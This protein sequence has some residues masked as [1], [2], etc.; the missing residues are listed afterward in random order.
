MAAQLPPALLARLFQLSSLF[1]PERT[2]GQLIAPFILLVPMRLRK[3]SRIWEDDAMRTQEGFSLIELLIVVAIILVLAAIA[4]PNYIRARIVANE[5]AAVNALRSITSA[6]IIYKITYSDAG[7]SPTIDKL[8]PSASPSS[9][10]A[11]LIQSELSD[12]PNQKSGYT[13]SLVGTFDTFE[14]NA[15]PVEPGVSGV[16][17]FCTNTPAAIYWSGAGV[18]CVAGTNPLN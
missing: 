10:H 8:G 7:Y 15:A 6:E 13:Y 3:Q 18:T 17:N 9:A 4:I 2:R 1:A 16:R 14:I 5:A 11:G 12:A